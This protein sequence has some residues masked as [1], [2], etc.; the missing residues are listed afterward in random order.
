MSTCARNRWGP[1]TRCDKPTST[2]NA[3]ELETR[4]AQMNETRAKQDQM[5]TNTTVETSSS[6]TTSLS[7]SKNE[8]SSSHA[9]YRTNTS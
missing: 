1:G 9:G 4:I 7:P 5:W 2:E 8:R 6:L 3:K